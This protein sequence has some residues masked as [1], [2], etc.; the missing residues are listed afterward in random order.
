MGVGRNLS[1]YVLH[2]GEYRAVAQSPSDSFVFTS[3]K[4][5]TTYLCHRTISIEQYPPT[6]T[7]KNA[8]SMNALRMEGVAAAA[9]QKPTNPI[10]L[11]LVTQA[12]IQIL[13]H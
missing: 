9:L 1:S 3:S 10:T 8:A 6:A 7:S 5:P 2:S 13:Y 4:L 11:C 12:Q